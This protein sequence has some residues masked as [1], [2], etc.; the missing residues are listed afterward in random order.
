MR[1]VNLNLFRTGMLYIMMLLNA[2]S[3]Q[4]QP[5][6]GANIR[7]QSVIMAEMQMIFL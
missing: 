6:G 2:L 3:V 1:S 4:G 7:Q 5:T